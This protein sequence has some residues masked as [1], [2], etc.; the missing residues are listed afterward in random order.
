[1]KYY[2]SNTTFFTILF[3]MFYLGEYKFY[4]IV[5]WANKN[6]FNKYMT[7]LVNMPNIDNFTYLMLI[8]FIPLFFTFLLFIGLI[9]LNIVSYNPSAEV[10]QDENME[11]DAK[12]FLVIKLFRKY[13]YIIEKI[14][15]YIS[16][17]SFFFIAFA[18]IVTLARIALYNLGFVV[19][20]IFDSSWMLWDDKGKDIILYN[21]AF[22][23]CLIPIY[24]VLIFKLIYLYYVKT[25]FPMPTLSKINL[26]SWINIL[27]SKLNND[28]HIALVIDSLIENHVVEG[29]EGI[30]FYLKK[31]EL[32][33]VSRILFIII[34]KNILRVFYFITR[35]ILVLFKAK[36]IYYLSLPFVYIFTYTFNLIVTIFYNILKYLLAFTTFNIY[37]SQ[38][39]MWMLISLGMFILIL[40]INT[41][42][43]EMVLK[44]YTS[45]SYLVSN[46]V[47]FIIINTFSALVVYI[48]IPEF[49]FYSNPMIVKKRF[50]ENMQSLGSNRKGK[51][52]TLSFAIVSLI[53]SFVIYFYLAKIVADEYNLY[54]F[55]TIFNYFESFKQF[56][57]N[58]YQSILSSILKYM[59]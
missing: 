19:D 51:I 55:E 18:F 24:F 16:V 49:N 39:F 40:L 13:A 47:T 34:L 25:N 56:L 31:F 5:N 11:T 52:R 14:L 59:R 21:F 2:T 30:G 32:G 26:T 15:F 38:V 53:L 50:E 10:L 48:I 17:L 12:E 1:M 9:A 57:T 22:F 36:Y 54:S 46:L 43:F 45:F 6:I 58:E 20:A 35:P 44:D 4:P 42:A 41:V 28:K 29:N 37:I 23:L 8:L 7:D 33:S 27:H 3:G